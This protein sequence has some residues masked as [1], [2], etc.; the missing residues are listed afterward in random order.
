[1]ARRTRLERNTK[2][3]QISVDLELDGAGKRSI[4]TPV[5]FLSHM[6]DAFARHGM[7]DLELRAAGDIEIDAHH[8]I[9]AL[10]PPWL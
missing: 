1:M 9:V 8:G 10:K 2:E 3:T 5:P 7:F 4:E 6:L